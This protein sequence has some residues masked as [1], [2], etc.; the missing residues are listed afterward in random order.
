MSGGPHTRRFQSAVEALSAL[1][2]ELPGQGNKPLDTLKL[3]WVA[4]CGQPLGH[5]TEPTAMAGEVLTVVARGPHWK[6]ALEEQAGQVLSRV[7]A[8]APEIRW[9]RIRA[10]A[11]K[12]VRVT[13]K[14]VVEPDPRNA[15]I[16]EDDLRDALDALCAAVTRRKREDEA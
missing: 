4:L 15:D 3:K 7:R 12:V 6:Q 5:F 16:E 13:P 14:P 2:A 9:I 8:V 10:G 11:P 1:V